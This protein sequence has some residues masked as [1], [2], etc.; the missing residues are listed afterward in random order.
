MGLDRRSSTGLALAIGA[1]VA[2]TISASA[3]QA[4]GQ[5]PPVAGQ[6]PPLSAVPSILRL[7][8]DQRDAWRAYTDAIAQDRASRQNPVDRAE[9]LNGL[10]TPERLDAMLDQM[11]SDEATF[12]RRAAATKA[13]YAVLTPDQKQTFDTITR[14]P[15]APPTQYWP[16]QYQPP[17]SNLPQPANPQALPPPT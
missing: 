8:P 16:P 17:V 11:K 7:Q 15:T 6:P 12:Q 3:T 4:Q 14:L 5:P 2:A 13:F 10:Q 1:A 9:K